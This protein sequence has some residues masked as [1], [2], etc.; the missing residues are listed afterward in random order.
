[1]PIAYGGQRKTQRRV[2]PYTVSSGDQTRLLMAFDGHLRA[3]KVGMEMKGVT[4][5]PHYPGAFR[6]LLKILK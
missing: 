6:C 3:T 4:H 5:L 2:S 1:M